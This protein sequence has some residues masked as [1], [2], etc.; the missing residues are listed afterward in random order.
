MT[1]G[2]IEQKR[3][4]SMIVQFLNLATKVQK[5]YCSPQGSVYSPALLS[6]LKEGLLFV[7]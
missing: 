2:F 3:V 4:M 6:A 1:G 7:L 5:N